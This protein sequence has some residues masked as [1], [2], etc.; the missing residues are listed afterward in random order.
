VG[1]GHGNEQLV[2]QVM[3]NSRSIV[4]ESTQIGNGGLGH[5]IGRKPLSS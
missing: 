5:L 4:Y 3:I 1:Q 2:S